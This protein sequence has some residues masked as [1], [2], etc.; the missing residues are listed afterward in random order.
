MDTNL[1]IGLM[2]VKIV[3]NNLLKIDEIHFYGMKIV[4]DM[5]CNYNLGII[6]DNKQNV[7]WKQGV[8]N[9]DV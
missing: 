9:E 3:K 8:G 1:S 6:F 4:S 2:N 5:L 7:E